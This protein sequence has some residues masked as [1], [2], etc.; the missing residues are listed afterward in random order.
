MNGIRT[1]FI[2]CAVLFFGIAFY[3]YTH[4]WILLVG[5]YGR[6]DMPKAAPIATQKRT[7]HVYYWRFN[8]WQRESIDMLWS[9][10]VADVVH[11]LASSWFK[12]L[13]E[14][15]ILKKKVSVQSVI[16]SLSGHEA[17]ISCDG[18]FIPKELPTIEKLRLVD[19]LLKT[20]RESGVSLQSV[21]LLVHHKLLHDYHLDFSYPWPVTGYMAV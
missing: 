8:A 13:D 21:Q 15:K 2:A 3:A 5:P 18:N 7:V 10:H 17:Y 11:Y 19:G 6:Y 1:F 16:L 20:I 9:E 4:D 14:E 12:L